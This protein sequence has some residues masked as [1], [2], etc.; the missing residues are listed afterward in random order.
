MIELIPRES[1]GNYSQRDNV[2]PDGLPTLTSSENF[3]AGDHDQ[4]FLEDMG[5][6]VVGLVDTVPRLLDSLF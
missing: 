5:D 2:L 1:R 4:T 3:G 6:M